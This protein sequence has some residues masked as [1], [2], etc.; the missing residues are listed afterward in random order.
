MIYYNLNDLTMNNLFESEILFD[1]SA[2]LECLQGGEIVS[3]TVNAICD[4]VSYTSVPDEDFDT[5]EI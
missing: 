2:R 3:Q 1:D 5:Q 4:C